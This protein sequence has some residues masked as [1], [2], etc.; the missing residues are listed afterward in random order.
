MRWLYKLDS[1]LS[2]LLWTMFRGE[3]GSTLKLEILSK[4]LF[5][6][7]KPTHGYFRNPVRF[8]EWIRKAAV[9]VNVLLVFVMSNRQN[10]LPEPERH[11]VSRV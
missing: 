4:I 10:N 6:K 7:K 9:E 3:M 11:W 8:V 1:A 5:K 2:Y